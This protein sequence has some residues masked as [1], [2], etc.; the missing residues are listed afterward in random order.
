[1]DRMD[2]KKI[3][4]NFNIN[5]NLSTGFYLIKPDVKWCISRANNF[6]N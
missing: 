3:K 2:E 6:D 5:L 4:L 1:M